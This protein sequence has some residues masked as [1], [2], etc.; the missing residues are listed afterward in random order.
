MCTTR[1][2]NNTRR[3]VRGRRRVQNEQRLFELQRT[4]LLST[5]KAI[6][7]HKGVA[8]I[9][10]K[11][12]VVPSGTEQ[13]SQHI[14]SLT[15]RESSGRTRISK[16]SDGL[17]CLRNRSSRRITVLRIHGVLNVVRSTSIET[18]GQSSGVDGIRGGSHFQD[19]F[20]PSVDITLT[21]GARLNHMVAKSKSD[22]Q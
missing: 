7:Q 15:D 21:I 13:T 12:D 18:E 16:G 10:T 6:T 5:S 4:F 8:G 11:V 3:S 19:G 14:R 22:E 9:S 20:I 17:L 2:G 1:T